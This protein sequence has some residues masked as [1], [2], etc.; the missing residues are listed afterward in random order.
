MMA[1]GVYFEHQSPNDVNCAISSNDLDFLKY[2]FCYNIFAH[3]SYMTKCS[4][5]L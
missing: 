1:Q 5:Q 2:L 4:D 3:V